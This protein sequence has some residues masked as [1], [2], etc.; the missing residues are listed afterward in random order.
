MFF[1]DARIRVC[2]IYG[3]K[4]YFIQIMMRLDCNKQSHNRE[5][6]NKWANFNL[7]SLDSVHAKLISIDKKF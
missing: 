4:E 7:S 5:Y 6:P 3:P 1:G 2:G